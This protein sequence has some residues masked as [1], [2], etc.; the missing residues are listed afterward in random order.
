[1]LGKMN[2]L[3]WPEHSVLVIAI[4]ATGIKAVIVYQTSF[5]MKIENGMQLFILIMNPLSFLLFIY[6]IGLFFKSNQVRIRYTLLISFLLSFVLYG[7]VAF[8]RFY[9]DFITLPVLFQTSN[10]GDLGS[11]AGAIVN[12]T[13]L[14]FF[15][16]VLL[17][18][19]VSKFLKKQ[20]QTSLVRKDVR[21]AYFVMSAAVL[22][23][24]LGLSEIER[25]QLLTRSFDRT[26]KGLLGWGKCV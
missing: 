5:D 26:G 12:F 18:I 23:L 11:S 7:N 15:F 25:P 24:N 16:D 6:G 9:N 14:F 8:Y 17:L 3:K 22:F 1:M 10:F 21:R 19:V 2:S 4:L 13:D 20:T